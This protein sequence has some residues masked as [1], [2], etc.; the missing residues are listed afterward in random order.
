M[1]ESFKDRV[2]AEH[3]DLIGKIERLE[4]F[5]STEKYLSLP[6]A[7]KIRLRLQSRYMSAYCET[8]RERVNAD[9]K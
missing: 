6:D 8:L 7:E 2:K 3:D 5:F 9:F 1:N 4:T